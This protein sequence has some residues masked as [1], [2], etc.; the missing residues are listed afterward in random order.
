MFG[1]KQNNNVF[2]PIVLLA[3]ILIPQLENVLPVRMDALIA[4]QILNAHNVKMVSIYQ[5]ILAKSVMIIVINVL[6]LNNA[7]FAFII[8][9]GWLINLLVY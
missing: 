8:I 1:S 5:T 3:F 4:Y 9:Y 6:D 7:H 2:R